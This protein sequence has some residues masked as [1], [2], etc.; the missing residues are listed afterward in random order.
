MGVQTRIER[1]VPRQRLRAVATVQTTRTPRNH[2]T[3][4]LYTTIPGCCTWCGKELRGRQKRWCSK[5]CS[6]ANTRN[7]R[8]TQA[9][10]AAKQEA[11]WHQCKNAYSVDDRTVYDGEE[12]TWF[13]PEGCL[14]FTRK[15][16]VNHII[17]CKGQ[18]GKWGCHHHSDNLEVLCIPCHKAETARQRKNKE[19]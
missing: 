3:C 2:M 4:E 9:K 19:F 14:I 12:H 13:G 7:H 11:A 17:P 18:H 8:W 5:A 15:P 1:H 10:A 6:R 16:E